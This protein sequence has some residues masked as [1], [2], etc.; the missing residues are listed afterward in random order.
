[1]HAIL[2]Q[3]L[4]DTSLACACCCLCPALSAHMHTAPISSLHS[5]CRVVFC[6]F[7]TF[8]WDRQ[9]WKL[10]RQVTDPYLNVF[11]GLVPP[12]MGALDLTPLLGFF[13]LQWVTGF[14]S[15]N[16]ADSIDNYW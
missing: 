8:E 1:M 5:P 11:T 6:W 3:M 13:V 14:L 16:I 9:P 7:P 4:L 15:T 2:N 12:L 10:L